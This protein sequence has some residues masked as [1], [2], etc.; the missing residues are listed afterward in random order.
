MRSAASAR[1]LTILL[2]VR[3]PGGVSL[4]PRAEALLIPVRN[5]LV[6]LARALH[7]PAVFEPGTTP[8]TFVVSSV[9]LFTWV[10]APAI[11]RVLADDAPEASLTVRPLGADFGHGLETGEIDMGVVPIL[12]DPEPFDRGFQLPGSLRQRALAAK[13]LEV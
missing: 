8:R 7:E 2:F 6:T 13:A 4:T 5:G 12:D 3:S 11:L 9:D 1:C 10:G